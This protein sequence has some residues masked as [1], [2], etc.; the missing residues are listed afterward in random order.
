MG[1]ASSRSH[2]R[3]EVVSGAW[4]QA[5]RVNS[6]QAPSSPPGTVA[7]MACS[8]GAPANAV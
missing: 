6:A 8:G 4:F 3:N 7:S 1:T 5:Y 2:C